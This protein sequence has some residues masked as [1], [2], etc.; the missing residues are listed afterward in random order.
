[1]LTC[2]QSWDLGQSTPPAQELANRLEEISH[3][4]A[5]LVSS[6]TSFPSEWQTDHFH[7]LIDGPSM[8]MRAYFTAPKTGSR[9]A[10]LREENQ[11]WLDAFRDLRCLALDGAPWAERAAQLQLSILERLGW[12]ETEIHPPLDKFFP[13]NRPTREMFY[14]HEG[15]RRFLPG[16]EEALASPR[17]SALWERF[18]LDLIHLL[19]H[20]IEH[21]ERGL[22]P[23]YERL[24]EGGK[25]MGEVQ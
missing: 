15:I 3:T 6:K 17:W 4:E 12:E 1:M 13:T 18:S 22:Y 11:S 7:V 9:L 10:K 8:F 23:V 20:H 2:C 21:E 25:G 14:E 5:L 16:L 24:V 19:E